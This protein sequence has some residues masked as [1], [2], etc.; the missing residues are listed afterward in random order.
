MCPT[1]TQKEAMLGEQYLDRNVYIQHFMLGFT[2]KKDFFIFPQWSLK[3]EAEQVS[4]CI[5]IHAKQTL[6]FNL[7]SFLGDAA[8]KKEF[9]R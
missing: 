5:H 6:I 8:T 2:C 3:S 1:Y 4:Q 9:F 7:H